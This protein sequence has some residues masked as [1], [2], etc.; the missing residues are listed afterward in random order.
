MKRKQE[1]LK[2]KQVQP[3]TSEYLESLYL[4][5]EDRDLLPR[6]LRLPFESPK[7]SFRVRQR[8]FEPLQRAGLF[9]I[10]SFD[11]I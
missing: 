9:L 5:F 7:L 6:F 4:V 2:Q 8:A 10:F 11:D 3:A 1:Q